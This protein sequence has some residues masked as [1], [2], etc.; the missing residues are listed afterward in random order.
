MVV[1]A[2]VT[3]SLADHPQDGGD[4]RGD[5]RCIHRRMRAQDRMVEMATGATRWM[6]E[7]MPG[8]RAGRRPDDDIMP[9]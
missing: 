9:R 5:T 6:G 1:T 2:G 4:H 3:A 8:G 7:I